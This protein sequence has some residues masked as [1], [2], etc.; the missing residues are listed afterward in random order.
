MKPEAR[1]IAQSHIDYG[2]GLITKEERDAI[3]G[4]CNASLGREVNKHFDDVDHETRTARFK[5]YRARKKN[6]SI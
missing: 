6:E 5:A 2:L 4:R 1:E 3:R